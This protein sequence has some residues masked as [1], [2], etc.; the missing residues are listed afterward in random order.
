MALISCPECGKQISEYA[1]TC[2]F[3]FFPLK[4]NSVSCNPAATP[5]QRIRNG[6]P[7]RRGNGTGS[8]TRVRGNL[9]RPYR[10]LV[11]TGW[12]FNE[13]SEKVTQK[14]RTLGYF[15]TRTEAETA[16]SNYREG[17]YNIDASE[18]TF[19]EVFEKWSESHY[20]NISESGVHG[21]NAAFRLCQDIENVRFVDIRLSHLQGVVDDC[22]KNYPTICKLKVLFNCLF[23]YALKN[24][25]CSKDYSKYVDIAKFKDRN[26]NGHERTIFTDDEIQKL[27]DNASS[28]EYVQIPLVLIYSGLRINE[29]WN[30]KPSDVSIEGRFFKVTKSKTDAGVRTVP[31]HEKIAPF[32]EHWL[33]KNNEY[34]F[35]NRQGGKFTDK[36]FRE[37][38][39]QPTMDLLDF[40]H[41]PHD[42]RHTCIS[43][44]TKAGVDDRFIKKIVGHKGQ[45]VTETVYTHLEIGTLIEAINKI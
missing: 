22:G 17:K 4:Q 26:P 44:L 39:W 10:V 2:G 16:L 7:T 1:V 40:Q 31:I 14:K 3:C 35:T 13:N 36:N 12:E 23:G 18:I 32:F 34:V 24:D 6:K 15:S 5:K 29:L 37:S 38:Y 28:D 45:G 30:L 11:T 8:I 43:L 33:S 20:P 25:I 41:L 19:K 9:K 27:W 21:Y 42:T